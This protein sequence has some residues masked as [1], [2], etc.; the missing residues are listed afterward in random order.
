MKS[1][2]TEWSGPEGFEAPVA[3]STELFDQPT[4]A[5]EPLATADVMIGS[6]IGLLALALYLALDSSLTGR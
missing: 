1:Y 6:G 4:A 2:L 3:P 5:S